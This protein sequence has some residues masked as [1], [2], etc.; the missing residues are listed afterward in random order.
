MPSISV[1][2]AGEMP[3]YG[4]KADETFW[5]KQGILRRSQLR[6]SEDEQ[7]IADLAITVLGE[8]P[9]A[10]S[11]SSLDQY[12]TA[13]T[14]EYSEID[15]LLA[16]YGATKLKNDLVGTLSVLRETIAAVDDSNNAFRKCVH[17]DAGGNPVKTAFYAVYCAFFELC[18]KKKK[19]PNNA[20]A[21]MNALN[22]LQ[23]KLDVAAGQIRSEPRQKNIDVTLGLIQKS[24]EDRQPPVLEHGAGSTIQF[25]NA[26]RRSRVETAAYECKQGILSLGDERKQ[27]PGLIEKIV[28]TVCA[29]A[30]IGPEG[31]GAI[32]IGVA[33]KKVDR[34][35]IVQ[36]DGITAAEIGQ[37]YVVGIDREAAILSNP[38]DKYKRLIVDGIAGSGL[39]EPLKSDVLSKID[40]ITYRGH[41]V[42]CIWVPPQNEY[43]SVSDVLFVRE[44]SSTKEIRGA[45]AM[46]AIFKRFKA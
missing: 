9:F 28:R 36:L 21:V 23:G 5:C 11:G 14:D 46:Q 7:M 6:D 27:E 13:G 8:K 42:V 31:D 38:L 4:V 19:S 40:V 22:Q 18:A 16:T 29:I 2:M 12:Y 17:P 39:S 44:G 35:R 37:R 26:I 30:N 41:S 33:D 45:K 25:E 32:F 34:D 43:S 24:F 15:K 3:E 1:D 10:F 20:P